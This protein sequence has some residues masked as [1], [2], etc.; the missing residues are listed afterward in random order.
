MRRC[1]GALHRRARRCGGGA[2]KRS[3]ILH[4]R[5]LGFFSEGGVISERP[6]IFGE[7]LY[8]HFPDDTYVLG[9][10][11]FNVAWHLQAFGARPLF[12]SRIGDDEL[13]RNIHRAMDDWGMDL[14]GLQLDGSHPTGLVQVELERGDATFTIV[15]DQ[16]YDFI[17]ADEL[18]SLETPS[19]LYHGSLALRSDVSRETLAEIAEQL[20][21]PVFVDVNLRD[22]WWEKA[23]V[24][25]MIKYATWLKL[26]EDELNILAADAPDLLARTRTMQD[27]CGLKAV[28][29]TRG[30]HGAIASTEGGEYLEAQPE[31]GVEVTDT[32]GAGDAFAAVL[33]LGL[34]RNWPMRVSL[35]RAQAFASAIVGV[36]GAT[37][38]D[39]GFYEKFVEE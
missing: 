27:R 18:P 33:V 8:D 3:S 17:D 14:A 37:V 20:D 39:A 29:V 24:L 28:W 38:H 36:R 16:A 5:G 15:P 12:I 35:T 10:A 7:V 13:G 6:L 32:V 11:P 4:T 25:K 23:S 22:P 19:L 1:A 21:A 26:N 34:I 31:A 2:E 30:E 9:G